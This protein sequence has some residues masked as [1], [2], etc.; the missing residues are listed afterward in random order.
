MNLT[1]LFETAQKDLKSSGMVGLDYKMS[2]ICNCAKRTG[3]KVPFQ[4]GVRDIG[5]D[6]KLNYWANKLHFGEVQFGSADELLA[7]A[8]KKYGLD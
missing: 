6:N 1:L 7:N 8:Y 3:A 2:V 5:Y 4:T